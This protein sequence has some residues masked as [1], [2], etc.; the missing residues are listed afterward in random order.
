[1]N[2]N[3][4]RGFTTAEKAQ[5]WER[6]RKD[7]SLKSIGRTFGKPSSS[8]YGHARRKVGS[9]L[10]LGSAQDQRLR[11]VNVKRFPEALRVA[12]RCVR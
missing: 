1:M 11:F 9:V 8:I 4:R 3:K 10:P 6:W 12:Y 7:Q 5:L 2:Q